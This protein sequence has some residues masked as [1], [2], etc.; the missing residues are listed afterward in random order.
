MRFCNVCGN[1]IGNERFC[2]KCGADNGVA[3]VAGTS[4]FS[5]GFSGSGFSFS[6]SANQLDLNLILHFYLRK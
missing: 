3:Q 2:N 6:G 1:D 4:P 5:G